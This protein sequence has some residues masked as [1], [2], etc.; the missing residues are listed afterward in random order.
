MAA[1]VDRKLSKIEER[2]Q[3]KVVSFEEEI[4]ET[5]KQQQQQNVLR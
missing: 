2:H 1:P 3:E 4:T 5:T